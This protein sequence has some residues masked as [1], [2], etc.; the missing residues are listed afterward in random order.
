[1][2]VA[3]LGWNWKFRAPLLIGDRMHVLITVN[4]RRLTKR[5]N[6]GIVTLGLQILKQDGSV[7]QEGST[8]LLV[9]SRNE[10]TT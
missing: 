5:G 6:R 1:M 8:E 7:V 9:R 3:S 4:E 10:G 2:G